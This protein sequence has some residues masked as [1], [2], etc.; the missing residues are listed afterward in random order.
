MYLGQIFGKN[1]GNGTKLEAESPFLI[2]AVSLGR[3]LNLYKS[4]SFSGPLLLYLSGDQ[5]G[6]RGFCISF[7]F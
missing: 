7:H 5:L 4:L 6:Q 1:I 3:C 2:S